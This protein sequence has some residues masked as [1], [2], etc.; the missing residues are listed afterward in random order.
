LENVT[1][2]NLR[3]CGSADPDTGCAADNFRKEP[4]TV[5]FDEL[6]GIV[7]ARKAA[8]SRQ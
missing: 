5:R 8:S 3:F 1:A 2:I 6:F 7:Q 4:H